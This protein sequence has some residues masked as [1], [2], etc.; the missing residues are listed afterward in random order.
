MP[1]KITEELM[2]RGRQRFEIFCS[3]C[4]GSQGDGNGVVKTFGMATTRSLHEPRIVQMGDGELFYVITHGRNTMGP[5]AA[6]VPVDDRW[7]IVAYVRA[8]QLAQLGQPG[9]LPPDQQ[10]AFGK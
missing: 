6:Q 8:L 10:V 3:P 9:D 2:A 7:A 1:V 4:H 5:Y